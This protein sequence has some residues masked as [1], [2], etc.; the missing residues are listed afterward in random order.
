LSITAILPA[1]ICGDFHAVADAGAAIVGGS[2]AHQ[3]Q[4]LLNSIK[5]HSALWVGK[6]FFDQYNEGLAQ[7]QAFIDRYVIYDGR[8]LSVD[9][10]AIEFVD[11][12]RSRLMTA[13]ERDTVIEDC[14]CRSGW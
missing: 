2:Q 6:L 3:P 10:I 7:R 5:V 1:P 4:R 13:E 9:P 14:V 11:M 12:A 8:V